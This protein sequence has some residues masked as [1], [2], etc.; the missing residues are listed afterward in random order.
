MWCIQREGGGNRGSKEGKEERFE[1]TEMIKTA[2]TSTFNH[3][4]L[5]ESG[6]RKRRIGELNSSQCERGHFVI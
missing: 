2:W 6:Q 5:A 1:G 3:A 4:S